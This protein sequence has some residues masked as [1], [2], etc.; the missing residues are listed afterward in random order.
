MF[1]KRAGGRVSVFPEYG[2]VASHGDPIRD[3]FFRFWTRESAH[4]RLRE[5][6]L[7]P[8]ETYLSKRDTS[9][10]E[11]LTI[12]NTYIYGI[13]IYIYGLVFN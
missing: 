12:M 4:L 6:Y 5:T 2:S 7:C 10:S 11:R 13:Y 3:S 8:R 1:K 9:L